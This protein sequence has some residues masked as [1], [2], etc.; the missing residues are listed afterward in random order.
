MERVFW[1]W[2]KMLQLRPFVRSDFITL[3]YPCRDRFVEEFPRAFIPL[4][5]CDAL[6]FDGDKRDEE[7][8]LVQHVFAAPIDINQC[9]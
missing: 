5:V 3:C 9:K 7:L 6:L 1:R 2:G 8:A 4:N